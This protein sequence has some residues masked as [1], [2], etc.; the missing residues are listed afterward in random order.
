MK[1]AWFHPDSRQANKGTQKAI[2]D[3][4]PESGEADGGEGR[5]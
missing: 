1:Q 2:P 3:R 5:A 4:L